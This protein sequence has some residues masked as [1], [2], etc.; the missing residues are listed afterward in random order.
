MATPSLANS[1]P[2]RRYAA[3]DWREQDRLASLRLDAQRMGIELASLTLNGGL[4]GA[5]EF[6]GRIDRDIKRE[7]SGNLAPNGPTVTRLL[8][9]LMRNGEGGFVVGRDG[10]IKS[11]VTTGKSSTGMDIQ[12]R[13]Y[14]K[15]A[16]AG[17]QSV[18]AAMRLQQV[19]STREISQVFL[20]EA[21]QLLGAYQGVVY[22]VDSGRLILSASYAGSEAV[23]DEIAIGETLLGECALSG[24]S[25]IIETPPDGIWTINSGLGDTVP[26][27]VLLGSLRVHGETLGV[28][29]L[30]ILHKPDE[31]TRQAFNE[32]LEVLAL[33]LSL[34]L[35]RQML[36]ADAP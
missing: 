12:F 17:K 2:S 26:A 4:M 23:K 6:L 19:H 25:R 30:A 31:D 11:S 36:P 14:F 27:A 13:P 8:K 15:A 32:I 29:E 10:I 28:V 24:D 35:R 21:H 18:Y 5:T 34:A 16:M 22:V 33:N 7:A 9:G 3:R 20:G 1:S